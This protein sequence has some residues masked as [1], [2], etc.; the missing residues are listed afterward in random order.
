MKYFTW[1]IVASAND[2]ISQSTKDFKKGVRQFEL[3]TKNYDQSLRK[4]R[5]KIP[6][7]AWE[8]FYNGKMD[9]SLHDATLTSFDFGD[10]AKSSAFPRTPTK[11]QGV[12][13][14]LNYAG[15]HLFCFTLRDIRRV[16]VALAA[17]VQAA[18]N[19][20]L[21]MVFLYELIRT[22]SKTFELN[23]LFESGGEIQV[24]FGMLEFEKKRLKK[25][26]KRVAAKRVSRL[27][28]K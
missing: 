8:F 17:E 24:E 10:P 1:E 28:M 2:W 26:S 18:S 4:L 19:F 6:G 9:E 14:F 23:V 22:P 20:G 7:P 21:G 5:G 25:A 16:Q 27:G 3:A 13:E 11:T 12:I 15:E